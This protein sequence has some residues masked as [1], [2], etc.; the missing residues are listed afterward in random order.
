MSDI[1]TEVKKT[2]WTIL[3]IVAGIVGILA[4]TNPSLPSYVAWF[5]Q[6]LTTHS[7][8][9][10]SSLASIFAG[11]LRSLIANNTLR[12]NWMVLSIY[13]TT[14]MG[15][16]VTVLGILGHFIPLSHS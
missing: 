6:S 11:P 8:A 15:Q 4:A 9:L 2:R 12:Q 1:P 5:D 10:V 16:Q 7:S 14:L 13:H 3:I